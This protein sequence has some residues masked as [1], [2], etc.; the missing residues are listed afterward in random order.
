ML[1]PLDNEKD[2]VEIP[3]NIKAGLTIKPVK[4]IDEVLQVALVA[5]PTPLPPEAGPVGAKDEKPA[6]RAARRAPKN[7]PA[8]H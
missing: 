1:I 4:W 7:V 3:E 6:R 2:L 8:A 5:Q